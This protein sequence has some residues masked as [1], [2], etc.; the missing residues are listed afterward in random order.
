MINS[1]T[2]N[3]F[4]HPCYRATFIAV[5]LGISILFDFLQTRLLSIYLHIDWPLIFVFYIGW[6]TN[7]LRGAVS[8]TI[9]GLVQDILLGV[10]WGIN[11]TIK[12]LIGYF[13]AYLGNLLNPDLG[14]WVRMF[15]VSLISFI[16]NY[17]LFES[18][19]ILFNPPGRTPFLVIL[20]GA[21]LTGIIGE[22]IFRL[23]DRIHS[24]PKQYIDQ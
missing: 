22:F 12:T 17:L 13:S 23:L 15:L 8:G 14:G 5:L 2:K 11:G 4:Y 9:F 7:P 1:F 24:V 16:N 21:L 3:E 10:L 20:S 18:H 19:H 6:S